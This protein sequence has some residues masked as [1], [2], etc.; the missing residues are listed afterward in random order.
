MRRYAAL[1]V[2]SAAVAACAPPMVSERPP[3]QQLPRTV[4]A[5]PQPPV[6]AA[7]PITDRLGRPVDPNAIKVA[8]L[9]PLTGPAEDIGPAM[10]RAAEMAVFDIGSPNFELM[11]RD[12]RGT[13]EGAAQAA[14]TALADGAQLILGPLF[15]PSVRPAA[16]VAGG[17][18]VNVVAFT[19][20]ASVAGGNVLVM[21]FVPAQQVDRVVTYGRERGLSRFAVLAPTTPYGETVAAAV[22]AAAAEAGGA[23]V[24]VQYYDPEGTEFS[25]PVQQLADMATARGIDAVMLPDAGLRLRTVAPMLPYFG[26]RRTQILGTG[27]WDGAG[28]GQEQALQGAWF[29]A[30]E[31]ALRAR[32]VARYE[33]TFAEPPPR[34]ATLAYDAVALAAVLSQRPDHR[35]YD[36]ARLTDPSGF[37]GV[38]G[39]FRFRDDGLVER[40]LAVLEVTADGATVIDPAPQSFAEAGF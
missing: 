2:L 22:D 20:D 14:R 7:Q 9:L 38:D 18:G 16:A 19:T 40:G 32:F 31:P 33:E 12:T 25:D 1:A 27:L 6:G 13:A 8:I 10:L 35:G 4:Q 23:L 24:H 37:A 36:M 17:G 11:P 34:L 3:L 15:S 21:G 29:A 39:I 5:E 26:L 30:P 28:V